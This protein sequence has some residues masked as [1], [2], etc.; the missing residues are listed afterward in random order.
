MRR[1]LVA[2]VV[3]AS[4]FVTA[5]RA[6]AA[7][8][9]AYELPVATHA[10]P[11]AASDSGTVWFIPR[12][13]HEWRGP[14]SSIL[15]SVTPQGTVAEHRIRGFRFIDDVAVGPD[16]EIWISGFHG[17]PYGYGQRRFEV[18]R[19]SS[20]GRV[21]GRYR[22]GR[23]KGKL[24]SL[25]AS[26]HGVWFIRDR[27]GAKTS[28]VD[29]DRVS[30]AG[31]IRRFRLRPKCHAAALAAA[32][33]GMVWFPEKC[34]GFAD[35]GATSRTSL[36]H[37]QAT[38]TMVRHRIAARDDPVS[39]AVGDEGTVWFGACCRGGTKDRIGRLT[40]AGDL[41]EFDIPKAS[42]LSLVAGP[43][44]HL[45]VPWF[46]RDHSTRLAVIGLD[47]KLE[48]SPIC[49]DPT[50]DLEPEY[51]TLAPD[52][53]IWYG[54][55]RPNYNSGGGGSGLYISEQIADE[56]GFVGHYSP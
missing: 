34:G 26:D 13:G 56:A 9:D 31:K 43:G 28:A 18:G 2:L 24:R 45:W 33:D 4:L 52:G 32:P 22:V 42:P 15:G 53:S 6:G 54:L 14:R 7:E 16:G 39:L 23:W 55:R 17:S 25:T 46:H 19:L 47:G 48:G 21:L 20:A 36:T 37:V 27:Y 11:L 5:P 49:A 40:R 30:A 38:G 10:G 51:L 35:G 8:T 3:A 44:G 1:A 50:C 12:R 41:E 29:I